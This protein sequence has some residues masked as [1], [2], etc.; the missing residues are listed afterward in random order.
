MATGPHPDPDARF[1]V[2]GRWRE[3]LPTI[4]ATLVAPGR[5]RRLSGE[6]ARRVAA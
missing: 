3:R 2:R 1:S 6:P 4:L 5:A